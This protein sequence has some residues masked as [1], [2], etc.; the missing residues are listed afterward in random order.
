M[1]RLTS[2]VKRG[3]AQGTELRPHRHQDGSYVVSKTRFEK[4]YVRVWNEEELAEW[5]ERGYS[6]R[7][8]NPGVSSHRAASL[9]SPDSITRE[10]ESHTAWPSHAAEVPST[11]NFLLGV[12]LLVCIIALLFAVS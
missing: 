11:R 2:T 10:V 9:I 4:D 3:K 6:V 1:I 5:V 12:A 8:S 7:M